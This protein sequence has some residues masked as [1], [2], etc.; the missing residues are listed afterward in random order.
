MVDRTERAQLELLCLVAMAKRGEAGSDA[1]HT[2]RA[3]EALGIDV[4]AFDAAWCRVEAAHRHDRK[5]AI[6]M[7][8]ALDLAEALHF[9]QKRGRI[10]TVGQLKRKSALRD[11]YELQMQS[12]RDEHHADTGFAARQAALP[13]HLRGHAHDDEHTHQ[14]AKA[15]DR[16]RRTMATEQ[17]NLRL[18]TDLLKRLKTYA[19]DKQ[20]AMRA[21]SRTATYTINDAVRDLLTEGL[22]LHEVAETPKKP[23][24]KR[25]ARPAAK[26]SAARPK[27]KGGDKPA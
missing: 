12:F 2:G 11:F 15:A 19:G 27:K 16:K 13:A 1:H 17:K 5:P 23:K 7:T 8:Y 24:A 18:D 4:A 20:T 10:E 21:L 9:L 3:S 25:P 6:T 26:K 14:A 22:E